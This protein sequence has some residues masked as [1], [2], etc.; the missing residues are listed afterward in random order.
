M[1]I[2]NGPFERGTYETTDQSSFAG[3]VFLF[4]DLLYNSN[5][6]GAITKRTEHLVEAVLVKNDSGAA[7]LPKRL[8]VWKTSGNLTLVDG[9]SAATAAHVAGVVDEFLPSAGVPNGA[10]FW[11]VRKGPALCLTD[12]AGGANNSIAL[13]AYLVALTA[14]TSGATTAGRVNTQ[15]LTGA[16]A[17]LGNQVQN[18]FG[19]ALSARTTGQTNAD[20]LV[21]M[22]SRF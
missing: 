7:L 4:D 17:L 11:M 16:T 2:V 1:S 13:H 22:D 3:R 6:T 21:Y 5:P 12:L 9:Y 15:D 14:A 18:R 10:W 8:V 19:K 20:I